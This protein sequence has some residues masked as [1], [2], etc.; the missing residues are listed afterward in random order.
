[1]KGGEKGVE[2]WRTLSE[3]A[4]RGEPQ[5][6]ASWD[7]AVDRRQML[8]LMGAS[9]AL[10]GLT[11][12]TAPP[13]EKIVPYVYDPPGIVPG[14]PLFYA[15]AMPLG[16][17]GKGLL[18]ESHMGRPTKVEG[19]PRHPA[20]LGATDLYSQASILSLYDPD[21]SQAPAFQGRISSWTAFTGALAVHL[22]AQLLKQGAGLRIL[23]E[24]V[25]SPTMAGQIQ[26]I[27]RRFP[28]ARWHQYEPLHNDAALEGSILAF[29]QPANTVYR[30]EN[31][32][33]ILC[34]DSDFLTTGPGW[35]RYSREWSARRQRESGPR[36]MN[37]LYVVESTPTCTGAVADHRLPLKAGEIESFAL[38]L[39]RALGLPIPDAPETAPGG[40]RWVQAVAED[41]RRHRGS[42]LIV[43]G[44]QQPAT[45]HALAHALNQALGNAG[46]TVIHTRPVEAQP[47]NHAQS[48]RELTE[49]MRRGEVDLLLIFGA[50][51]VF[52]AP[53]DLNFAEALKNVAV[54]VHHGQYI[55]E[56]AARCQWHVP[57]A[58]YL[59][60]WSDI[61]A[62]DGTATIIQPL[63]AP[64]YGGYTA[65]EILALL[66]EAPGR[67]SFDI[68]R[69]YW[70]SSAP[71]DF[72]DFWRSALEAGIVPGTAFPP[73]DSSARLDF[74]SR[75]KP[76]QN[77]GRG[78]EI[79]F[80]PDPSI[81][82]GRFA[83]NGWL[84][85]L[86]R[87]LTKL[88][89][90]NAAIVSP[91][92][93][94]RLGFDLEELTR[95]EMRGLPAPVVEL[96]YR[97]RRAF[98]PVFVLPG[99]PDESV[100]VNLGY[101]RT[102]AGKTGNGLGFDAY[103]LRS[104]AAPWF[105]SGLRIER[106]GRTALLSVT[107]H[108]FTMNGRN[109]V[110]AATIGEIRKNPDHIRHMGESPSEH[111]SLYPRWP[112]PGYKWAMTVNLTSC[113]GCNSCVVACAAENNTPVVGREQVGMAR[114]MMW[115]RIDRYY[116]GGRQAPATYFQP[117]YCVHC[118]TAPCEL[119]CPTH[120][121]SHSSEGLNQMAYN[122]CVGTRYCSNN[123]PYKVRRFNFLQYS[124]Y[125]APA[126]EPV[127][128]PDVT[129]RA[130]GVMEKCTYC[131]Q[132]IQEAKIAAAREN[133]RLRDGEIVT[134][135]QQ[136]CPTRV[137]SFGDLNDADSTVARLYQDPLQYGVLEEL[138]THPR[139]R[140]LAR[141][142]N[143]NPE[144]A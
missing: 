126:M 41:L 61:R 5:T 67:S 44:E 124:D 2:Q 37:R 45:V 11:A 69:E 34:L 104:S 83:N 33:V 24:T 116:T 21:R 134:A 115:L 10:A 81:L 125:A 108:H 102:R 71:G 23:T 118:E 99:H 117:M 95:T 133:R 55:D 120:A 59:E 30:L 75:Q 46:S 29:G 143:P 36:G 3:L 137:F 131:V 114:E 142:S 58:H 82:D 122:R 7:P 73:S 128:N 16:G 25:T 63:I 14:K 77:A 141:L 18:V 88:T 129:V 15:T 109:P 103:A 26:E 62:F 107:Q 121:T 40:H 60:S 97:G 12:C 89:W 105:D 28:R 6:T 70:R 87:P 123:C 47:V 119:V 57:E 112:Y 96:S 66:Q 79:I 17:Y 130:R 93:A 51:P 52:T 80:R 64:V 31:A 1:M 13:P 4:G 35:L 135:C 136:A 53:P 94:E 98:A 111:E 42:S 84:Q 132:R 50:N 48:L 101:G 65:H 27:L 19:N 144:L 72:E 113:I 140:H 127:Y 110:R 91:A 90:G 39:A 54:R 43:A 85:E 78:L 20:S 32:D 86:P 74:L 68:V 100:T 9:L 106:T 8:K 138:N 49:D 38:A 139:T 56:T 76:V 22:E 92:T